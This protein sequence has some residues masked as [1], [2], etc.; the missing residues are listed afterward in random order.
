M[1]NEENPQGRPPEQGGWEPTPQGGEYDA[2]AT[3]F[4]QLPPES[5]LDAAPLEA[6]GHGYVP[7]MITPLT[8]LSAA[9]PAATDGWAGQQ[10]TG[11]PAVQWPE[12]AGAEQ[13]ADPHATGQWT[14]TGA[15]PAGQ[16]VE[17]ASAS[18]LTGQ[19]T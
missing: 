17:P 9:G 13:H 6:P 16:P 4:L 12:P 11:E 14:F 18:E 10:A 3:A 15:E 5:A 2:E 1:S 7:P 8:P 19:W